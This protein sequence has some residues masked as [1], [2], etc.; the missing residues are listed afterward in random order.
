[1]LT[2]PARKQRLTGTAF[3][4]CCKVENVSRI[5]HW[6]HASAPVPACVT[7]YF[8]VAVA[9]PVVLGDLVGKLQ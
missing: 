7:W 1:M 5:G 9:E 2:G 6:I 8:D 4:C 3:D